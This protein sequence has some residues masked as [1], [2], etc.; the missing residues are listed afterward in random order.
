MTAGSPRPIDV[1]FL[2]LLFLGNPASFYGREGD[3]Y[4]TRKGKKSHRA[5]TATNLPATSFVVVNRLVAE[6]VYVS[7]NHSFPVRFSS[8]THLAD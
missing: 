5:V 3:G 8:R 6:T 4:N 7:P 2:C 1:V